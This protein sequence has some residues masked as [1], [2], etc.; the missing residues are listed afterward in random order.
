[1]RMAEKKENI[2]DALSTDSDEVLDKN[3][4][5]FDARLDACV[6]LSVDGG[7]GGGVGIGGGVRI[8]VVG[9]GCC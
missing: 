4:R 9:D 7:G 1:M 5:E 2:G 8:G 6:S 3:L